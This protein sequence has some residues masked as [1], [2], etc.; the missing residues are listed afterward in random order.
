MGGEEDGEEGVLEG[1][2]GEGNRSWFEV[3]YE[4][5]SDSWKNVPSRYKILRPVTD[6]CHGGV[7][8]MEEVGA[9]VGIFNGS[10]RYL[11]LVV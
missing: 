9:G 10:N 5:V 3:D 7:G 4:A 11:V 6:G 8:G 2:L 1:V